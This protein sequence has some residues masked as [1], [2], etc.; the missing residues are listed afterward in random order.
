MHLASFY[1]RVLCPSFYVKMIFHSH[2]NFN[3]FSYEWLCTRPR[4]DSEAQATSKLVTVWQLLVYKCTCPLSTNAPEL[5]TSCTNWTYTASTNIKHGKRV[6]LTYYQRLSRMTHPSGGKTGYISYKR[7]VSWLFLQKTIVAKS[8][9]RQLY[10]EQYICY[11]AL[12]E[13]TNHI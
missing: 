11:W 3:S 12:I 13:I 5:A 4:F 1:K 9:C 6:A 8:S 7:T 2:A 10:H